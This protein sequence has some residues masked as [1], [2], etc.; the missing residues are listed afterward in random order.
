MGM[1]MPPLIPGMAAAGMA[2]A[3][4]EQQ[5]PLTNWFAVHHHDYASAEMDGIAGEWVFD[6]YNDDR[7]EGGNELLEQFGNNDLNLMTQA[8]SQLPPQPPAAAP[9]AVGPGVPPPRPPPL[10]PPLPPSADAAASSS[11]GAR[12]SATAGGAASRQ[13]QP[14]LPS[15]E[16][17]P[18]PPQPHAGGGAAG[19]GDGSGDDMDMDVD[20]TQPAATASTADV[21]V[22][23]AGPGAKPWQL[24]VAGGHT[25]MQLAPAQA[26]PA[27]STPQAQQPLSSALPLSQPVGGESTPAVARRRLPTTM[28]GYHGR[29]SLVTV[30]VADKQSLQAVIDFLGC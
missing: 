13:S 23:L 19:G 16:L 24:L 29:V 6:T 15:D 11:A 25:A 8:P 27:P 2:F 17:P 5:M 30:A 22:P 9:P 10:P 28:A 3:Q 21:P 12:S 20:T 26:L 4:S 7:A 1:P 18:L 14:P